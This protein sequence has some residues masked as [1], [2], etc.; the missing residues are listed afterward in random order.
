MVPDAV[1]RPRGLGI[2]IIPE[3][4]Q[5][6]LAPP[7]HHDETGAAIDLFLSEQHSKLQPEPRPKQGRASIKQ[8]AVSLKNHGT[9]YDRGD[10]GWERFP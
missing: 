7:I 6:D 9:D 3:P 10:K 5:D 1:A 2:R 4:K 8:I